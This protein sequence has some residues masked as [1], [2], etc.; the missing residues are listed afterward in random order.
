MEERVKEI[1]GADAEDH[2]L[3]TASGE[4]SASQV[5]LSTYID[6]MRQTGRNHFLVRE[7]AFMLKRLELLGCAL[8]ILPVSECGQVTGAILEEM[9]K[10]RAALVSLP[11]ADTLT[12]VIH[13][14]A[15]LARLCHEKDV[16]F[17]VDATEAIGKIFFRFRDLGVDFLSWGGGLLVKAGTE[18]A[19]QPHLNAHLLDNLEAAQSQFDHFCTETVRLR[20][21]LERGVKEGF[22]ESNVL[23]EDTDRLP[24]ISA[25]DFPG[26]GSEPLLYHLYRQ[27]FAFKAAGPDAVSFRLTAE[28]TQKEIDR[29]IAAIVS[30]AQQLRALSHDLETV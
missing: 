27:G 15:E 23:F 12:G 22:P 30:A 3:T 18:F 7:P 24:N 9:I 20:N 8:K 26:V 16:R 10:P 21:R 29:L 13:P 11:W 6:F 4:D 5:Y 1:L 2:L 25:I 28:T 14:I 17:H 19:G